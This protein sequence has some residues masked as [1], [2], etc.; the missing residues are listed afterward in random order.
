[1][2]Q[3]AAWSD[4]RNIKRITIYWKCLIP[5]QST[6]A[7]FQL[8][9]TLIPLHHFQGKQLKIFFRSPFHHINNIRGQASKANQR[10][11][12]LILNKWKNISEIAKHS[13]LALTSL[14]LV[15]GKV[16]VKIF[17]AYNTKGQFIPRLGTDNA[18]MWSSLISQGSITGNIPLSW[19]CQ[20]LTWVLF[21]KKQS[22]DKL[23]R[24]VSTF[25][26]NCYILGW[27]KHKPGRAA[28]AAEYTLNSLSGVTAFD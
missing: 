6:E 13:L 14:F 16:T 27:W 20:Q 24:T 1:M 25:R 21:V 12:R 3:H 4:S 23:L 19:Y 11:Q 5:L 9:R 17:H 22:D 10:L 15:C 8:H 2:A 18:R 7:K 26:V 28:C